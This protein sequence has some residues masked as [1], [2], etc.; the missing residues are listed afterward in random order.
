ME[1]ERVCTVVAAH[2]WYWSFNVIECQ[3]SRGIPK[4][5]GG[6]VGSH[7]EIGLPVF[8]FTINVCLISRALQQL[9]SKFRARITEFTSLS[10]ALP[11]PSRRTQPLEEFG[12]SK[13]TPCAFPA[14]D[15]R[16]VIE[17][18]STAVVGHQALRV[19]A[20]TL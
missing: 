20:G 13:K 1:E 3:R 18:V 12:L 10:I 8:C 6:L 11:K 7:K 2:P 5:F 16:V 19:M 14:H 17:A 9:M 15:D 4:D